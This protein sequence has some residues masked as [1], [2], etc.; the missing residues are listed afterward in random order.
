M[1]ECSC[2]LFMQYSLHLNTEQLSSYVKG[3]MEGYKSQQQKQNKQKSYTMLPLPRCKFIIKLQWISQKTMASVKFSNDSIRE[4][5]LFKIIS[6]GA[7]VY[8]LDLFTLKNEQRIKSISEP[9]LRSISQCEH[10]GIQD[11]PWSSSL[12]H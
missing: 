6:Q 10:F 11:L 1:T 4:K 3:A 7:K 12:P 9:C 2:D 8:T 5:F